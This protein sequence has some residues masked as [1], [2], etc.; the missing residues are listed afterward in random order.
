M[1]IYAR[2][3]TRHKKKLYCIKSKYILPHRTCLNTSAHMIRKGRAENP[4]IDKDI[5]FIKQHFID[6]RLLDLRTL[7]KKKH[8]EIFS[9]NRLCINSHKSGI[10]I[11]TYNSSDHKSSYTHSNRYV[12]INIDNTVYTIHFSNT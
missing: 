3:G 10:L 8:V 6:I 5:Y 12:Y 11:H 2:Q 9:I 4:C 1:H 7:V